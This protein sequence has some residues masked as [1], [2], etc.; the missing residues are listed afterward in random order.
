MIDRIA[1]NGI[2]ILW[3]SV[4]IPTNEQTAEAAAKFR[5]N[6]VGVKISAIKNSSAII[7]NIIHVSIDIS[8]F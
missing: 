1:N 2:K 5:K 6:I 7:K 8:L 3:L 4:N